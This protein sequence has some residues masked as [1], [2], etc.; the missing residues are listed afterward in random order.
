LR[1]A[2][3]K[4]RDWNGEEEQ[5]GRH[6]EAVWQEKSRISTKEE[7][8][9]EDSGKKDGGKEDREEARG[10]HEVQAGSKEKTCQKTS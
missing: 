4:R 5:K 3:T 2:E 6:E 8:A 9:K 7:S 1:R 10:R